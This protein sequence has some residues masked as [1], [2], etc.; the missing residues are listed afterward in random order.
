M[1][2]GNC[3]AVLTAGAKHCSVCGKAAAQDEFTP[4]AVS[5]GDFGSMQTIGE[6]QTAQPRRT[7]QKRLEVGEIF[8]GRYRITQL[9][10]R[11]GM[12][13]VY[14]AVDTLTE[15]DVALKL[16]RADRLAGADA[17]KRLIREGVTSR[18]IRHPNVIAVY[19]VGEVDGQP[20]MSME[21]VAGRSLRTFNLE[22]IQGEECSTKTASNII[23]E[24]LSGLE[25]AHRLG[26]IHRDLK[27]ENVMLLSEPSEAGVQLKLLD[28]GIA[29]APNSGDTGST[30]I[31]TRGYMAPEQLT[32]PDAAQASADLYSLSVIFYELL[33]GV[34][35]LTYWQPPSGGRADVP[36]ALDQLIQK[37]LSSSPRKRY[38]NV[39]EYRDAL[40]AAMKPQ[41]SAA[42]NAWA[43]RPEVQDTIKKATDFLNK[44]GLIG[45]LAERQ[46][47]A[48]AQGVKT[49]GQ[50]EVHDSGKSLWRW[51]IHDITRAYATGK[52]RAHRM[53]Y[54]GFNL[55]SFIVF[56]FAG[57]IDGVN[58]ASGEYNSNSYSA[59]GVAWFA[60]VTPSVALASRR[61]HDLGYSGWIAALVAIPVLGAVLAL[62]MGLPKGAHGENAYGSD[63]LALSG[64]AQ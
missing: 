46:R 22:H 56:F 12:G 42:S 4:S 9:I 30:G 59:I 29:R 54:W 44:G 16:I 14:R 31:G 58:A 62:L 32:A 20:F 48:A 3:Q 50:P 28:F 11:G 55:G 52:G 34:V 13:I 53:E 37:G 5:D 23:R 40:E 18:D 24:I 35:P 49:S 41:A 15:K 19:D 39:A 21:F 1:K 38:Q 51:F 61:M 7:E 27:P 63:P 6:A 60:L 64:G 17:V 33:V 57:V 2:C 26:V 47:M 43:D 45:S 10:G 36:I 25:A 8:A